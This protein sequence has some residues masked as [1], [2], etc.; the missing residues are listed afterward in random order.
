MKKDNHE[1]LTRYNRHLALPNFTDIEQIKLKNAKV[2]C[3]GAGG[4]GTPALLYL[5]AA[6]VGTL[7]VVDH[8]RIELSNLQ[9]QILYRDSDVGCAK[10]DVVKDQLKA[11]N[12][13]VTVITYC[14]KLTS[15]NALSII[16][17]Y[18]IIIDGTD[19]FKTRYMLSDG[20]FILNKPLICASVFQFSGQCMVFSG[21]NGP[22]YRC[23]FPT[24]PETL[25]CS[26][27]GVLGTVPGI[28][29][30]FQANE[31]IKLITDIGTPIISQMITFDALSLAFKKIQLKSDPECIMCAKKTSFELLH[32]S[33]CDIEH[34]ECSEFQKKLSE[35]KWP[36]FLLDVRTKEEYANYNI[37]GLN[38]PLGELEQRYHEIKISDPI[39]VC[40]HAGGRSLSACEFLN[41]LGITNIK[42]LAGGLSKFQ[43]LNCDYTRSV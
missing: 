5:T 22:C 7:G 11:Y 34:I 20:A 30:L 16:R 41:K 10:V 28:M 24:V 29:G 39:I 38:I 25:N 6:G 19:N 35:S 32:A 13:D 31:V 36:F 4:L 27:A 40:C 2:L 37:G 9:R 8:D 23:L 33:G 42:N 43:E 3:V 15:K 21:K 18:D 26:E 12:S 17:D 14:E 1:E